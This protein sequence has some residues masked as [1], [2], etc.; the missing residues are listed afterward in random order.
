MTNMAHYP[1]L[2]ILR[3][4]DRLFCVKLR[5]D[6][7][8]FKRFEVLR[9]RVRG[10]VGA[11]VSHCQQGQKTKRRQWCNFI[12]GKNDAISSRVLDEKLN[13]EES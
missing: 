6:A 3:C 11:R 1:T 7:S 10:C 2:F 5:H 4:A 13:R 9:L 12:R 8:V